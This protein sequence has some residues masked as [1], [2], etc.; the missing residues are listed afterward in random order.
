[1]NNNTFKALS[2]SGLLF[3]KRRKVE[4]NTFNTKAVSTRKA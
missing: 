2:L 4:R 3:C 1:M